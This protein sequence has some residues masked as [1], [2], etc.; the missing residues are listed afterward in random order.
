MA[1][2]IRWITAKSVLSASSRSLPSALA[3]S[4]SYTVAFWVSAAIFAL[5]ALVCGSLL[6]KG[7]VEVDPQA[8]P[9]L[10]H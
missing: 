5:G 4:T 10:A 3:R 2:S 7:A 8:E 6:P 9:V 1:Q